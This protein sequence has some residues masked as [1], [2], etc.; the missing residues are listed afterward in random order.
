MQYLRRKQRTTL[1][2]LLHHAIPN[3]ALSQLKPPSLIEHV[4]SFETISSTVL[5]DVRICLHGFGVYVPYHR[6]LASS[7]RQLASPAGNR[8][9]AGPSPDSGAILAGKALGK[10]PHR[11][12]VLGGS[13]GRRLVGG[14][15]SGESQGGDASRAQDSGA[16][17]SLE[18]EAL[19][20]PKAWGDYRFMGR[21]A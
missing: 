17:Q 7:A 8:C 20:I 14:R 12:S 21:E 18:Q 1:F 4:S 11:R 13:L 19:E 2:P 9:T 3:Q 5:E 6:Q 16:S 15:I 10:H